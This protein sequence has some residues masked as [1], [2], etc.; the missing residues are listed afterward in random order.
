LFGIMLLSL[1]A[2]AQ[3]PSV[4]RPAPKFDITNI[5]KSLDPCVDFY[6]YAC[7]NWI[8]NN[9]TPSDYT[10]WISFSEVEEHNNTVLRA[11]LEKASANDAK[12]SPVLQKIGDF[13]T[14]CMDEAAAN[15][16]G[17]API[18]PELDRIAAVKDKAQMIEVM[19]HETLIGPTP[20]FNFSSTPDVHNA[21]MTIAYIDQGCTLLPDR[22]YY[23]KD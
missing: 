15:K 20:L 4:G 21:A 18:Q 19:A 17:Y 7:S 13:Y 10:D 6:Q 3:Q 22:D 8:K 1:A 2:T 14:A 11:I 9:P 16:K 12:R 5:D 23:L